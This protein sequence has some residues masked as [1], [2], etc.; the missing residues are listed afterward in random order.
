MRRRNIPIDVAIGLS[1]IGLFLLAFFPLAFAVFVLS[2]DV[3]FLLIRDARRRW[4]TQNPGQ[5]IQPL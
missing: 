4:K 2:P 5:P 1:F 3:W